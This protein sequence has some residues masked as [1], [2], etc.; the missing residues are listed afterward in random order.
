MDLDQLFLFR[1]GD[2]VRVRTLEFVPAG[3]LG[4]I[5]Q[6]LYSALGYYF[7]QLDGCDESR[8]MQAHHLERVTEQPE[9]RVKSKSASAN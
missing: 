2:R 9:A 3:K 6:V 5:E 1:V 8:L 4:T 7:V